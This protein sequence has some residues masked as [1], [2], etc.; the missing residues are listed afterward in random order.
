MPTTA[1]KTA[2]ENIRE[3]KQPTQIGVAPPYIPKYLQPM[4][5]DTNGDPTAWADLVVHGRI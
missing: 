5:P 4:V 1:E 3:P 2:Q